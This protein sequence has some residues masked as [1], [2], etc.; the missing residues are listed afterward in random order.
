MFINEIEYHNPSS[1]DALLACLDQYGENGKLLAGGT[2]L[3]LQMKFKR[4]PQQHIIDIKS[5][6]EFK[7]IEITASYLEIGC[8]TTLSELLDHD[9]VKGLYPALWQAIY[10][11]ADRQIR[12]RG[13]LVG[14]VCNASPAADANT[15]LLIYH[16]E[17]HV[18][19]SA[20][21]KVVPISEFWLG[22]GKTILQ[23]NEFV[24]AI[25]LPLPGDRF[26]S[27]FQK[28]GRTYDDIAIIN[29]AV[30]VEVD[31]SGQCTGARV[32][33]GAVGP[34]TLQAPL[35][36]AHLLGKRLDRTVIEEA[37]AMAGDEASPITDVRASAAYRKKMVSVLVGR[38]LHDIVR[39]SEENQ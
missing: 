21:S 37:A 13:T 2:D 36:A 7:K 22:P 33:M 25:R 29:V 9:G 34:T 10:E 32:A 39:R 35:A 3:I 11:L 26:F 30:S 38:A 23:P 14:N 8:S 20:G 4:W 28:L 27:S 17:V 15:A 6:A 24:R 12:N 1:V 5:I 31:E 19:S 16:S 18:Q